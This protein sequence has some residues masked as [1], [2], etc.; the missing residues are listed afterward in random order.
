VDTN[1]SVNESAGKGLFTQIPEPI[2]LLAKRSFVGRACVPAAKIARY[3]ARRDFTFSS[4][5]TIRRRTMS[6]TTTRPDGHYLEQV[7]RDTRMHAAEK[8]VVDRMEYG[9]SITSA[10]LGGIMHISVSMALTAGS[11]A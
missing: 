7:R 3:R 5:E 10:A 4:K 2:L 9:R 8:H 6:S 11:A 1:V